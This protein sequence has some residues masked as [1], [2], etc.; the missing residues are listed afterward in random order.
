MGPISIIQMKKAWLK[1]KL[2]LHMLLN[3]DNDKDD[4]FVY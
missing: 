3:K 2:W 1:I 4:D